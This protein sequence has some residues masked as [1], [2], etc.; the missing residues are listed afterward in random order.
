VQQHGLGCVVWVV[1][2]CV[3]GSITARLVASHVMLCVQQQHGC[4]C[5]RV[6]E[7]ASCMKKGTTTIGS[8]LRE[9]SSSA[10]CLLHDSCQ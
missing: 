7:R 2:L 1:I 4:A 9:R 8:C 3:P 5:P 6:L 10:A